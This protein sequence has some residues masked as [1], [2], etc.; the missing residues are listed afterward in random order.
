[1]DVRFGVFKTHEAVRACVRVK[2]HLTPGVGYLWLYNRARPKSHRVILLY[3]LENARPSFYDGFF[4]AL[5][6]GDK[7]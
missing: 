5:I 2:H 3:D 6:K 4:V 7:T 1:M